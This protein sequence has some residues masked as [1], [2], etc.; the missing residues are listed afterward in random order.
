VGAALLRGEWKAA[1]NLIL[2]PRDG[3]ILHSFIQKMKIVLLE[4][5]GVNLHFGFLL[6]RLD[7]VLGFMA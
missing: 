7:L 2:Q 1:A 4:D 5:G 6:Y 3:D